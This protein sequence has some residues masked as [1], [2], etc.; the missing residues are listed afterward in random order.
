MNI[1]N[2][3]LVAILVLFAS[4][5]FVAAAPDVDLVVD[6]FYLTS[7]SGQKYNLDD[8]FTAGEEINVHLTVRNWG[9]SDV[10]DTF[11]VEIMACRPDGTRC[12]I[13]SSVEIHSLGAGKE[14]T[15]TRSFT[16]SDNDI[17]NG[18]SMIKIHV[19]GDNQVV[20]TSEGNN[21]ESEELNV[22]KSFGSLFFGVAVNDWPA[23]KNT[24]LTKNLKN[25][26]VN[27]YTVVLDGDAFKVV[28]VETTSTG[29]S[30]YPVA[31]FTIEPSQM[32]YFEGF[33]TRSGADQG[34]T[35]KKA[36]LWTAPPYKVFG[37]NMLCQTDYTNVDR[38]LRG[39]ESYA[40]ATMLAVPYKDIESVDFT[41][42][43]LTVT[44][45]AY[46]DTSFKALVCNTGEEAAA[47]F[48]ITFGANNKENTLTYVPTLAAGSCV[49]ISSWGYS[50][51][52]IQDTYDTVEAKVDVDSY[53]D[54]VESDETNNGAVLTPSSVSERN[55][56][57]LV[58]DNKRVTGQAIEY[59]IVSATS[60]PT[61]QNC[62]VE[63]GE[64]LCIEKTYVTVGSDGRYDK[65]I[66][67]IR[68]N[69]VGTKTFE[70]NARDNRFI[71]LRGLDNEY[72][73]V[74]LNPMLMNLRIY[75][76]TD[77][78]AESVV[79]NGQLPEPTTNPQFLGDR[80]VC[81]T[82]CSYKGK[83]LDA[84]TRIKLGDVGEF[85]NWDGT[86]AKQFDA[87]ES[88]SNNYECGTNSCVS[89]SCVDLAKRLDDQQNLLEKIL[90]WLKKLF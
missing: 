78:V 86:M 6:D 85:C 82:G 77:G 64:K 53:N 89:G 29:A 35:Q 26:Y 65:I 73:T 50:H 42:P 21:I 83:C 51:F 57:E 39:S 37:P 72:F 43:D 19:D 69:S 25:A 87:G 17:V 27:M 2:I 54:I 88:C 8:T 59:D 9:T 84:G 11:Q 58:L 55:W 80:S 36:L 56:V 16:F 1:K 10:T 52:G 81:T 61:S 31:R 4:S 76:T 62:V 68:V 30:E 44:S 24:A 23:H 3:L 20:E 90:E 32:V 63:N 5:V 66:F 14:V 71:A 15:Y 38:M 18:K 70:L 74:E 48:K 7:V 60:Y 34:A 40:C 47:N 22:Q 46:G 41:Y 67:W 75:P 12:H 45:L 79:D 49:E 13:P 33:R 28:S